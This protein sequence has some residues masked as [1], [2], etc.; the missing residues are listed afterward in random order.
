MKRLLPALSSALLIAIAFP[1]AAAAQTTSAPPSP[2]TE[3]IA[4]GTERPSPT[5]ASPTRPAAGRRTGASATAVPRTGALSLAISLQ[6]KILVVRLDGR[7]AKTYTVAVGSPKH[8]TPQ[9]RYTIRHIVWN[10]A[11]APPKKAWAK[12]KKPTPPGHP[13]NPMKVVKIFFKEPDYYIHG[14]ADEETLGE[15]ASHGCIRMSPGEAASL[16][17][18]LMEHGGA[19][20]SAAWFE[21]VINAGKTADIHLPV[22][23]PVV[24][25]P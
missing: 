6:K 25:G 1:F 15:A 22:G 2:V 9:G 4:I 8:Q 11:W 12:G 13:K 10:P 23:I 18:Y 7:D 19:A 3:S 5:G 20:K 21:G 16:A 14:T 17:R 24:L